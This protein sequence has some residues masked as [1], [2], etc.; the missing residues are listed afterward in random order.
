MMINN[1][2]MLVDKTIKLNPEKS[3]LKYKAGKEIKLNEAGFFKN[4][5]I[6]FC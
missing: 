2:K 1:N 3:V 4:F 5:Q 6:I